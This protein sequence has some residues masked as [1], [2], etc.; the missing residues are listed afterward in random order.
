MKNNL[1]YQILLLILSLLIYQIRKLN[2]NL[3]IIKI[4]ST[5]FS[6]LREYY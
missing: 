4:K 1:S 3:K 2:A 6:N 5:P